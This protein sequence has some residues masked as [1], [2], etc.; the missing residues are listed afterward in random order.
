MRDRSGQA[1]AWSDGPASDGSHAASGEAFPVHDMA[2]DA[3]MTL[4][5]HTS[6]RENDVQPVG[7]DV[8]RHSTVVLIVDSSENIS[9]TDKLGLLTE[10]I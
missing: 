1:C 5:A 3:F 7:S 4:A 2:H 8:M 6:S 10:S 9:L